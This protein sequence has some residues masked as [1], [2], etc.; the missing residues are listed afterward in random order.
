MDD[1]II[2]SLDLEN[3]MCI[4]GDI[5]VDCTGW[6]NILGT[7]KKRVEFDQLFC[8]AAIAGHI[9]YNDR[10]KELHPY[11]ISEAVDHGWIWNIPVS[12]RIG[13]G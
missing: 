5:F 4:K 10:E 13:S 3:G 7:P 12:S 11:V 6:K 2:S 1:N 9:P 8:N